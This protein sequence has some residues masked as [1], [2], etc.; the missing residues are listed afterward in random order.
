MPSGHR[1]HC[2]LLPPELHLVFSSSSSSQGH[3]R[4]SQPLGPQV[5]LPPRQSFLPLLPGTPHRAGRRRDAMFLP[6]RSG[7][8]GP[9]GS[10]WVIFKK[11]ALGSSSAACLSVFFCVKCYFQAWAASRGVSLLRRSLSMPANFSSLLS[12]HFSPS[13]RRWR[14]EGEI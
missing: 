12:S 4:D 2:T 10:P 7:T 5:F 9:V 11:P 1:S 8:L 14:G 6:T 13:H 3:L